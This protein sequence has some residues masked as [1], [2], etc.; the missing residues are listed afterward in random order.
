MGVKI[1]G[2][3]RRRG[4]GGP[5]AARHVEVSGKRSAKLCLELRDEAEGTIGST[6]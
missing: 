2:T 3:R 4:G 5:G 6:C 1:T